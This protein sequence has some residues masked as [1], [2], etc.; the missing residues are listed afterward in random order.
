MLRFGMGRFSGTQFAKGRTAWGSFIM[1]HA[2]KRFKRMIQVL[3]CKWCKSY[4]SVAASWC[5]LSALALD[6][7]EWDLML[8]TAE[9]VREHNNTK[10]KPMRAALRRSGRNTNVSTGNLF[11]QEWLSYLTTHQLH[12]VPKAYLRQTQKR[13][14][15]I[16][17]GLEV[18]Q[19]FPCS[20]AD[21]LRFLQQCSSTYLL[22]NRSTWN[23]PNRRAVQHKNTN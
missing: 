17:A 9:S 7:N 2:K 18:L 10:Q 22:M 13:W 11:N 8:T 16:F 15:C 21:L 19:G 20:R 3:K 5:E 1:S 12:S 6:T 23:M 14:H 4:W